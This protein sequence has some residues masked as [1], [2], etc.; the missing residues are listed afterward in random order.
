MDV[1]A[2]FER[3]KRESQELN[4]FKPL[5]EIEI[6]RIATEF[7]GIPADYLRFL[8]EIG[9]GCIGDSF[10]MIYGYPESPE[11]VYG[12]DFK[13]ILGG[14]ILLGDDFSG[15]NLGFD[16]NDNWALVEIQPTSKRLDKMNQT[17]SEFILSVL[18][19]AAS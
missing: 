19:R 13:E 7:P 16:M 3:I 12:K 18:K 2:A 11:F 5:S 17:F 8:R 9:W 14:I 4:D 10:Y 15:Y 6:Q 1:F